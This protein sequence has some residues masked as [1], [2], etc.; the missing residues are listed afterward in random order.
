MSQAIDDLR[1]EHDAILSALDILDRIEVE[2]RQ[3]AAATGDIAAFIRALHE[4][5]QTL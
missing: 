2:A 5:L 3:G 1:R 4:I